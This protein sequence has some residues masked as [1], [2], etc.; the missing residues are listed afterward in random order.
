[1]GRNII[2][3][4]VIA[5]VLIAALLPNTQ[6][7]SGGGV[8]AQAIGNSGGGS[9]SVTTEVDW[10][11][12]WMTLTL[13]EDLPATT[14][15]ETRA[16]GN[17]ILLRRWRENLPIILFNSLQSVALQ[18]GEAAAERLSTLQGNLAVLESV[19]AQALLLDSVVDA[20]LQR[21]RG[22][23]RLALHP[24]IGSLFVLHNSPDPV[25]RSYDWV[26]SDD[27]SGIVIVAAGE[28]PV[29]G[30]SERGRAQAALQP[31]IYDEQLRLI[32]SAR[33]VEPQVIVSS[34]MVAYDTRYDQ[35]EWRG[36]VGDNPLRI[37]ARSLYNRDGIDIIIDD[38]NA[39]QILTRHSN[40]DLIRQGKIL[41]IVDSVSE[42][43]NFNIILN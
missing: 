9:T 40:R 29:R 26:A 15:G 24:D 4:I 23:Y 41:I 22:A 14:L 33:M 8:S 35:L 7:G 43:R 20:G 36:R 11:N 21:A 10:R 38:R 42:Q 37:V 3:R 25:P 32:V 2:R 31:R 5:A 19:G 16:T 28:L 13:L 6:G 18:S 34:G 12:G 17:H 39:E 30:S 1:M 27:F